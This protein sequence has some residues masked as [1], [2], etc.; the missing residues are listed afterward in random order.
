MNCH[1]TVGS[2]YKYIYKN[3]QTEVKKLLTRIE[4]QLC[5]ERQRRGRMVNYMLNNWGALA[6]CLP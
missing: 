3:R 2:F 1:M 6:G 4:T 5:E